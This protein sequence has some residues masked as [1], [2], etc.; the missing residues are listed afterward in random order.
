MSIIHFETINESF[1]RLNTDIGILREI[2]GKFSF[3]VDGYQFMTRF[4]SGIWDGYIRPINTKNGYCP[5]GLVPKV[6]QYIR[7]NGYEY[8]IDRG[9]DRFKEVVK[10]DYKTLNLPHEPHDYQI[11]ALDL[12]LTKKRQVILSATG[13][14]KSMTIYMMTHA[15]LDYIEEHQKILIVV[16]TV[17]LVSQMFN[18]FKDYSVNNGWDVDGNVHQ[19]IGGKS[20]TTNKKILISTWQSLYAI[21]ENSYFEQFDAI[22]CDEVHC[23]AAASLSAIME[24]STNAFYRVGVS[25]TLDGSQIA[26]TALI[27]HFGPIRRVSSTSDLIDRKILAE[28]KIFLL[29][30][31]YSEEISKETKYFDYAAEMDWLVRNEYR[32]NFI[33][34]LA[35]TI[36]G[37]TLILIQFIEKQGKVLEQKLKE[38]CPDKQVYFVYGGTDAEDRESVRKIAES[39]SNVIILAS[40]PVFQAGV[41]IKNLPN[42]ILG[43]PTKSVIRLLQSIGRGLRKHDDK[44]YCRVYDIS[45]DL[46]GK[47]K[48]MNYTL[49]HCLERIK[50]YQNEGFDVSEKIIN[51]K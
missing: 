32:N 10:F 4:K 5:K 50:I 3:R 8:T 49:K 1:V 37:N 12:F 19:I 17:G 21:K 45:D 11:S 39:H 9:F 28:L 47:R 6:M 16:P 43:S 31:T 24:R 35:K 26:E 44:E 30:L 42:L 48:K 18:D 20:K 13:S 2:S 23:A 25:G 15:I 33:C 22:I 41:N 27:G 38:I 40:Y 14:G 46:R 7:D 51:V 34:R 36:N 29:T